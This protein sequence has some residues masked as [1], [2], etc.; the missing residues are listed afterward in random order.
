MTE[1]WETRGLKRELRCLERRVEKV[2]E[3]ERRLRRFDDLARRVDRIE[4]KDWR[5]SE[6]IHWWIDNVLWPVWVAA[7]TALV[8]L[9][10]TVWSDH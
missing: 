4:Q 2:E 5:R 9:S 7:L 3:L 6:R 1:D 8:V 10:V